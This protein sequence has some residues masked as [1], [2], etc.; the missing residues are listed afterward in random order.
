MALDDLPEVARLWGALLDDSSDPIFALSDEGR[1]LYVNVAFG[2]GVGRAPAELVGRRLWDVFPPQ[3]ADQRFAAV[4][5]VLTTGQSKVIEVAVGEGAQRRWFVTT[6]KPMPSGVVSRPAVLCISKDIT[7]RKQA[8]E[9][10]A[11]LN[12]GLERRV[13]ARTAELEAANEQ[14]R[15]EMAERKRAEAQSSALEARFRQAQKMEAVGRLAGGVAHDYNNMLSV[16]LGNAGLALLELSPSD[17]LRERI[18]EI[19][20][21]GTRSAEL[22]RQLLAFA[23]QE[24]VA[25]RVVDM[26]ATIESMLKLLR[27]LIGESIELAWRPAADL[28]HLKID[29]V[30]LHQIVANL[31]VNARDAI[32]DTGHITIA[33][34]NH[35]VETTE[36]AGLADAVSGAC[37]ELVVRDDGAGMDAE[38][39][40]QAFEPFFTTK[41][42]GRGTGLGLSTVY[43][44]VR[45][46]RGYIAVQSAPGEGTEFRICLPRHDGPGPADAPDV[47]L[48]AAFGHEARVLLV[49]DNAMV[50]QTT[51]RL[52]AHLGFRVTEAAG[53]DEALALLELAGGGIEVL[54]TDVVMPG[55]HGFELARRA[56]TLQP[57]LK[58]L[59][60]TGYAFD[61][62]E[63]RVGPE[64]RGAL[65]RKPVTLEALASALR[66][67]MAAP[68]G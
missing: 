15:W 19:M 63:R 14:L 20:A 10:L 62:I 32:S 42:A 54:V 60:M 65:L 46:N 51:A 50:R 64:A 22:T 52:L 39:L 66:G 48:A 25:P 21:A 2:A 43:G 58:T 67:V 26:N 40:A 47:P 6:V 33:T 1:Y 41:G 24:A 5:D 56:K 11:A 9:A 12:E 61:L 27:R 4:R 55:M 30:Q 34:R 8:E 44:I 68:E 28:G 31:V 7:Q 13:A 18:E 38:T 17:P 37:V 57:G 16:I 45:Q 3:A 36:S 49:E 29:P 35:H 53:P 59:H 23:R